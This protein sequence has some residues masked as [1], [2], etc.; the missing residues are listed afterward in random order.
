MF[1]NLKTG[2]EMF[3]QGLS[4]SELILMTV[5]LTVLALLLLI[6]LIQKWILE[7]IRRIRIRQTQIIESLNLKLNQTDQQADDLP[8]LSYK[9]TDDLDVGQETQLS[10]SE[11]ANGR[12]IRREETGTQADDHVG[13][14]RLKIDVGSDESDEAIGVISRTPT[15]A[16]EM[17]RD[18]ILAYLR[19]TKR[20]TEYK[21]ILRHVTRNMKETD[22]VSSMNEIVFNA[23]NNMADQGDLASALVGGKL[24]CKLLDK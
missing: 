16:S 22:G 8:Y 24:I 11:I 19:R 6:L 9:Q 12:E 10:T 7:D 4:A 21:D 14:D 18:E 5:I 1:S 17:I 13:N 2:V 15:V 23:I 3:F 20:P